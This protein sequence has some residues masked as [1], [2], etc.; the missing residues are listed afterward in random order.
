MHLQEHALVGLRING[1]GLVDAVAAH[2]D[3]GARRQVIRP[4]LHKV[5]PLAVFQIIHF[6]LRM[7][8]IVRHNVKITFF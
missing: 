8:L 7:H 2:Q 5:Q 3:A 1:G 6:D 4:V